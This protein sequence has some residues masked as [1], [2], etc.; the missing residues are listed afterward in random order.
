MEQV[1]AMGPKFQQQASKLTTNDWYRLRRIMEVA[2]TVEEMKQQQQPQESSAATTKTATKTAPNSVVV[3]DDEE[4]LYSGQRQGGLTSLQFGDGKSQLDVRCFFL[5]PIDRMTHAKII[6]ERCERM[7]SKGLI[8]ETVQLDLDDSDADHDNNDDDDDDEDTDRNMVAMA[9]GYRQT[10]NY[11][12]SRCKSTP[13]PGK[14]DEGGKKKAVDKEKE[15]EEA[16]FFQYVDEFA[17]ATRQYSKRQMQWFRRDRQFVF[18]PMDPTMRT[19]TPSPLQEKT[20]ILENTENEIPP[21]EPAEVAARSILRLITL[22]RN[23]FDDQILSPLLDDKNE[24]SNNHNNNNNHDNQRQQHPDE[25]LPLSLLSSLSAQTRRK[26]QEQGKTMKLFRSERK[27][28][29]PGSHALQQALEQARL[30]IRQFQDQKKKKQRQNRR[31]QLL[32]SHTQTNEERT[33]LHPENLDGESRRPI[34]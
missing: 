13:S 9:I 3:V 25:S 12:K 18:V 22:P 19:E 28:L 10:L 24:N 11:L 5:C 6:D 30:A 23:E 17:A 7:I 1:N 4:N 2:F 33:L 8:A 29:L 21:L 20:D 34:T 31:S 16:A 15:E 32:Q 14:D 26:N 27:F